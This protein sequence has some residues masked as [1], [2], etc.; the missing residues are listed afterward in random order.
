MFAGIAEAGNAM[1][2]TD[3]GNCE[4]SHVAKTLLLV[5]LFYE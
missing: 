2:C 3:C 5:T 4:F 1:I